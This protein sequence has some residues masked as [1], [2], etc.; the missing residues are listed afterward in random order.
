[1]P[2]VRRHPKS[3]TLMSLVS[4]VKTNK[5]VHQT[6]CTSLLVAQVRGVSKLAEIQTKDF[7]LFK[8][9][10]TGI[11]STTYLHSNPTHYFSFSISEQNT[12]TSSS[13][14]P[15]PLSSLVASSAPTKTTACEFRCGGFGGD[16]RT[17]AALAMSRSTF[18]TVAAPSS[19]AA[20]VLGFPFVAAVSSV[21]LSTATPAVLH[22]DCGAYSSAMQAVLSRLLCAAA[23]PGHTWQENRSQRL[24]ASDIPAVVGWREE[25]FQNPLFVVISGNWTPIIVQHMLP[26]RESNTLHCQDK[27]VLQ[28]RSIL[29]FWVEFHKFCSWLA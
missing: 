18:H 7:P 2:Y 16:L 8:L 24:K 23:P 21:R 25:S 11:I 22:G 3:P 10:P 4:K 5:H 6:C 26:V 20:N 28:T 9:L 15:P 14:A 12:A 27:C 13:S 17:I 19:R 1:M 29:T